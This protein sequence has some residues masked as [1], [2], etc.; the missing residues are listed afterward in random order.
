MRS[1][2]RSLEVGKE[3]CEL[4]PARALD[5]DRGSEHIEQGLTDPLP[6]GAPRLS[7]SHRCSRDDSK[8]GTKRSGAALTED[9]N[10]GR[11]GRGPRLEQLPQH[12]DRFD[13]R[14]LPG[15]SNGA[16]ARC[17]TTSYRCHGATCTCREQHRQAGENGRDASA[18]NS[19]RNL[20][21]Y[22]GPGSACR[23]AGALRKRDLLRK[24]PTHESVPP[25]RPAGFVGDGRRCRRG[26]NGRGH[27]Q[28]G[29]QRRRHFKHRS[30]PAIATVG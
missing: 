1:A 3:R 8:L 23:E 15:D 30:R 10:G 24:P 26:K 17:Q 29:A 25:R 14:V 5:E 4:S 22:H 27:T 9:C 13:D 7:P 11:Y 21:N 20:E 19:R 2:H 16:R 18:G 6:R 12:A 28:A